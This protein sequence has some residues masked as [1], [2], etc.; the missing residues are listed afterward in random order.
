MDHATTRGGRR[1]H[2]FLGGVD[3]QDFVRRPPKDLY[4]KY[5]KYVVLGTNSRPPANGELYR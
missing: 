4:A 3:R 1:Q 2:L 5:Y